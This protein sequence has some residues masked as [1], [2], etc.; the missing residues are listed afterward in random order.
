M[1]E[2]KGLTR[3]TMVATVLLTIYALLDLLT[4]FTGLAEG[5]PVGDEFRL[6]EGFQLITF[7][8]IIACCIVVGRWIYRASVNAHAIT[9]EMTISPGWSVGWYFIPFANL[10]KPFHAMREIWQA[11][12]ESD[13]SYEERVPILGWWWG[14]WIVTNILANVSWRY[15]AVG[16]GPTLDA[17]GA[18]LNVGLCV[19]LVMIMRDIDESQRHVRHAVTFA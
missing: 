14:L 8:A 10:V 1:Y 17:I 19:V 9:D 5:A 7:V 11:S 12:H 2:F 13:G 15:G 6:T 3:L 18:V 4:A 16:I